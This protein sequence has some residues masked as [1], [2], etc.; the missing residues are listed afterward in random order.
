MNVHMR[1]VKHFS[2][3]MTQLEIF[4]ELYLCMCRTV[5]V[6]HNQKDTLR[7]ILLLKLSYIT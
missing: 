4:L 2:L 6:M 7:H 1:K 3:Q 5:Y